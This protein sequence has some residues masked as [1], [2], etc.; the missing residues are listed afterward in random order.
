LSDNRII[1]ELDDSQLSAAL[2]KLGT[3][4][5]ESKAT[6]GDESLY[7]AMPHID[8]NMR[9]ILSRIPGMREAIQYY[10]RLLWIQKG[11]EAIP[12]GGYFLLIMTLIATTLILMDK[13]TRLQE[14]IR[15]QQEELERRIRKARDWSHEDY[16]RNTKMWE[17]YLKGEPP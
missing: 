14:Q 8:R 17:E 10:N 6:L 3:I 16:V 15:R 5:T 7:R 13:I 4:K 11:I 12:S 2:I 9:V 1:I